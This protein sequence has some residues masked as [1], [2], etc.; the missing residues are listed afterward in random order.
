MKRIFTLA[1][2]GMFTFL[3]YNASAQLDTSNGRYYN[4]IF[5]NVTTST[6]V[7]FGSY[8]NFGLQTN[9]TMDIYQPT[10]DV[11]T[12]RPLIILA[13][14]GS[15]QFGDKNEADIVTMCQ[16]F[17]KMGYVT[18]SINY[19]TGFFPVDS[20]NA[21]Q[22]VLKATQDM[23]AAVRFFRKDAATA[24]VYKIHPDYV[25]VG[26]S[27]AGAF[28]ALHLAYMDK[29]SEFPLGATTLASLGGLEGTSG[30]PGYP[31][32]AS[33]VINLCGALGDASYLEA[34][35]IPFVS[36]HGDSDATVPYAHAI[37]V[38]L[39]FTV[40]YVDGSSAIH[41][42]AN[43]VGVYNP[44]YTFKGADHVPYLT[45]AP[46][47]DTTM[48]YVRDFLLPLVASAP[49]SA[50]NKLVDTGKIS[51]YP[52]PAEE[53]VAVDF[54]FSTSN[55]LT[56]ELMDLSGRLLQTGKLTQGNA[57]ISRLGLN[58]GV[59]LVKFIDTDNNIHLEKLVLR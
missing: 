52:N 18:C 20:V 4:Q 3:N 10:G 54:D 59:Y 23:K 11:V 41:A 57:T 19:R 36:M 13:H 33:A 39:G 37:I 47:L 2:A 53:F 6:N 42:R 32:N 28:M 27:S 15:F 40:M 30:N 55:S 29:P 5:P 48:N 8:I 43:A 58:A 25:Y 45:S 31:S 22:A 21:T 51:I 35:D 46:Y 9:L 14:G 17:A 56:F 50:K 16:T 7:V 1:I 24:N 49:V 38:S 26:G 34:G 44:F 12:M